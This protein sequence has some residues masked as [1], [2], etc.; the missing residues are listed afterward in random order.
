MLIDPQ[1]V[2]EPLWDCLG[3]SYHHFCGLVLHGL[4]QLHRPEA[5]DGEP[6]EQERENEQAVTSAVLQ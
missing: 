5:P 2:E 1:G 6:S 3:R 4:H